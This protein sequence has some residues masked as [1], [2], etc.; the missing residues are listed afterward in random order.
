M[1]D[2]DA[3]AIAPKKDNLLG[4]CHAIGQDLGFNPDYLRVLLA[5]MLLVNAEATL[6]AYGLAGV[7]VL[8]SRLLT[9]RPAS[10]AVSPG[11][12]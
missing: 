2:P 10:A 11:H 8:A 1:Q 12:S 3:P 7:A 9:R 4:I 6:I 5:I